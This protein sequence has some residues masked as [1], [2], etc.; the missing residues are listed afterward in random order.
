MDGLQTFVMVSV[1]TA[2]LYPVG[3]NISALICFHPL[4]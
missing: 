3:N 4:S 2:L 1:R